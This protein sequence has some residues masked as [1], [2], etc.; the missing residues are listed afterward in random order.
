MYLIHERNL[1]ATSEAMKMHRSS[2]IYR[3][4]KINALLKDDFEDYSERMYLILSYEMN[5]TKETT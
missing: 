3:F 1:A 2:L 4:K 5:R